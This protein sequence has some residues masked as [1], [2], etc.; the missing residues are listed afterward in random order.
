MPAWNVEDI[1]VANGEASVEDSHAAASSSA[2][3]SSAGAVSPGLAR[4]SQPVIIALLLVSVIAGIRAAGPAVAGR[5]PLRQDAL[6]IGIC[7]W[8]ALG[9]LQVALAIRIRRAPDAGHLAGA[10]R[11][12]AA[13]AMIAIIVIG[14]VNLTAVKANSN[15]LKTL[16]GRSQ[17]Q[18]QPKHPPRRLPAVPAGGSSYLLY[19]LIALVVL[20]A[21]VICVVL[22]SRIRARGPGG[23]AAGLA[24]DDSTELHKAV[25]SGRTALRAVDDAR[26]A[27][28]ACY[29]AMEG[30]LAG[31]GAA[32]TAAETP[33]ELL[34]R[35]VASGLIRRPAAGRLTGLFYEARFSSHPLADAAKDDARQ[36]LDVISDEL[37]GARVVGRAAQ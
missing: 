37:R 7:L 29:V 13:L 10:L 12:L 31:A 14:V 2:V 21:L 22:I 24:D 23:Y 35:A 30:S 28:I 27:I 6:A 16:Q 5:G 25:E 19:A 3:S 33:D 8:A 9:G 34:A 36:A 1:T 20:V 32:R 15:W 18:R 26:A 17:R 4:Y 11:W